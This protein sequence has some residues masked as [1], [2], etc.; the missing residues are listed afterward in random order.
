[1]RCSSWRNN[2]TA[3]ERRTAGCNNGYV[4]HC[5]DCLQN[6]GCERSGGSRRVC[7]QRSDRDLSDHAGVEYGRVGRRLGGAEAA[8]SVGD[9][10]ISGRDGERGRRGGR[11]TRR[12]ADRIAG[13]D[14][15]RLAGAA[16]DDSEHVQDRRRIDACGVSRG[17]AVAGH[18]CAVDL[19]RSQRRHGRTRNG[20]GDALLVAACRRR[21]TSR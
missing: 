9:C 17:G 1:M 8:E 13:H 10:P 12:A 15:H 6:V 16:A 14:L 18:A 19:R 5:E 20:L 4:R 7:A 11:G 21:T 2:C 3:N